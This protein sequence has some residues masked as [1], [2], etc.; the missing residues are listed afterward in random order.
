M[1]S[2]IA[3]VS[4]MGSHFYQ[5]ITKEVPHDCLPAVF[6]GGFPGG[7][8][9]F[10]FDTAEGGA[11]HYPG[12]PSQCSQDSLTDSSSLTPYSSRDRIAGEE[13][14]TPDRNPSGTDAS[15][16]NS[17]ICDT[18]VDRIV[19][20]GAAAPPSTP[21]V[22][23]P[24]VKHMTFIRTSDRHEAAVVV[25]K[26]VSE[27]N[28][29]NCITN[30]KTETDLSTGN[31]H[32]RSRAYRILVQPMREAYGDHPLLFSVLLPC[33][34]FALALDSAYLLLYLLC[35]LSVLLLA[36]SAVA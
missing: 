12:A 34:I 13:E 17:D 9:D 3:K 10:E 20:L 25:H 29:H 8:D 26:N 15:S 1:C 2:T 23:S 28:D 19:P 33:L 21:S 6:G 30:I 24:L 22:S 14:E 32:K 11:L 4:I 16:S 27:E 18:L 31:N 36:L 5:E 7:N 35:S